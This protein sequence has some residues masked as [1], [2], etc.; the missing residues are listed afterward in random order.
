M[1]RRQNR[2]CK[3]IIGPPCCALMTAAMA[4]LFGNNPALMFPIGLV[5]GLVGGTIWLAIEEA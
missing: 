4:P 2:A 3:L 1:T 5:S